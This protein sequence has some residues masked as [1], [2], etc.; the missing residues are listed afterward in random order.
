MTTVVVLGLVLSSLLV[1]ADDH[2][3]LVWSDEFDY[4]E[5]PNPSL[6]S[7]DVG[8]G[9]WGNNELQYYT[10][11]RSENAR[12]ENGA[13]IIEA[14]KESFQ[15][16]NYTSARVISKNKGDWKYGRFEIRAKLPKGRGTWPAVWML[17]TDWIYGGWPASGE[18]DIMEHVGYDMNRVHGTI[19]T[20]DFNH[21]KGTQIG[22]SIVTNDVDTEFH[23]Y[24]LEWHPNRIDIFLDDVLYFTVKDNGTGFGAWPFDQRFHLLLNIAVG[25][26]WGGV[27]GV[28]DSIF[29][30][31]M[32]V[33]YVRVYAFD[34]A[35]EV[36]AVSHSVPG[37]VEAEQFNDQFGFRLEQTSDIGGG[38]NA[39]FLADEDWAE[40]LLDVDFPGRYA[41]D[42]RYASFDGT[43]A[44]D[45]SL[46]SADPTNSGILAAT[47]GWQS[48]ETQRVA[49]MDLDA[50]QQTLRLTIDSPPGEDL[51]INWID[52]VLLESSILAEPFSDPEMDGI[53]TIFE[54]A[55]V[56]DH[57]S[58]D[59]PAMLPQVHL[60]M[61][62]QVEFIQMT[63][64]QR[65][66]G[67][68]TIGTNYNAGGVT[69]RMETSSTLQN[70][71]WASGT[72]LFRVVGNPTDNGDGS[73]TVTVEFSFPL[74]STSRFI[75]LNLITDL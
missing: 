64:R 44:V 9:G 61:R 47:G 18:I 11:N 67:T 13:L 15:G 49:Q 54:H 75:R 74:G 3:T 21:T 20:E 34:E 4:T 30:Q 14:R 22:T 33:D 5:Q 48:W 51:N 73:E 45:L 53:P 38:T 55:F 52:V 60:A 39:G 59:S 35:F 37:K 42:L 1:K 28:D 10:D 70:N 68:G 16:R 71:S 19:H 24:A 23:E 69:Y 65:A 66:G 12:V 31:R 50:G 72:N 32:E 56:L 26:N 25:G 2:V 8:S 57:L 36:E 27:Q 6:W 43:A 40:Y 63:Y 58:Q 46:N 62:Q 7:Y 17:P 29:P 41:F